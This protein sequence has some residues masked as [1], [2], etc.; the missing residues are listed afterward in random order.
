MFMRK[1]GIAVLVLSLFAGVPVFLAAQDVFKTASGE[2]P[3]Y[4]YAGADGKIIGAAAEIVGEV[5]NR[6]KIQNYTMGTYPWARAMKLITDGD[7]K[8]LFTI[9]K[10]KEREAL[11]LF[12]DE[13]IVD[14]K[15]VFF[16][17]KTDVGKLK[18]DSFEDLKG[19]MVGLVKDVKYTAELWDFVKKENNY[20]TVATEELNINKLAQKRVD[21]IAT[22]LGTGV[23][24]AKKLGLGND[25]VPLTKKPIIAAPI[26]II[27][28]PK[29]VKKDFV[30]AFSNELK[31]F[32]TEKKYS[33]ILKKHLES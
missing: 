6:L 9:M 11:F 33:D 2:F 28:N 21:F 20:E 29:S 30:V 13:P 5:L 24:L 19:K 8:A 10:N 31:K 23:Y 18:Y 15:W 26:Y 12:P 1:V 27:F 16:I 7:V 3:P 4:V 17:R 14:S 25:I 32:K 22:E